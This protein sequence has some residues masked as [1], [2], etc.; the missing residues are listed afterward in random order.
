MP[1]IEQSLKVWIFWDFC[2]QYHLIHTSLCQALLPQCSID[3]KTTSGLFTCRESEAQR[4]NKDPNS[5]SWQ[6]I[7]SEAN[8]G[9]ASLEVLAWGNAAIQSPQI[10]FQRTFPTRICL[11]PATPP[12]SLC[13]L[14]MFSEPPGD[15]SF[16]GI[17]AEP[18]YS[19]P[20]FLP[21]VRQLKN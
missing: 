1:G 6:M 14:G 4:A 8:S 21:F 3:V 13:D 15:C 12:Q 19:L 11:R 16:S 10:K 2:F 9:G 20:D 17:S 5:H 7:N 18:M